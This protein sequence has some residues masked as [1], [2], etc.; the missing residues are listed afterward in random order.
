MQS[1][2][3][4]KL[5][6][7]K[8]RP[9]P[10]SA[11]ENQSEQTLPPGGE[12]LPFAPSTQQQSQAPLLPPLPRTPSMPAGGAS[13]EVPPWLVSVVTSLEEQGQPPE[14]QQAWKKRTLLIVLSSVAFVVMVSMVI[15]LLSSHRL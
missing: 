4:M 10:L 2:P 5:K 8:T 15:F 9:F 6:S 7:S 3:T 1:E 12:T 14:G 11:D 13:G